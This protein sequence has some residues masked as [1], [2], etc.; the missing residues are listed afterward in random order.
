MADSQ[1]KLI[2]EGE[3]QAVM[4]WMTQWASCVTVE[5]KGIPDGH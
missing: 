3:L 5:E 2:P 4:I 1:V